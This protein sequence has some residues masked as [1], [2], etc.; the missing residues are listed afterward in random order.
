MV[1]ILQEN[2]LLVK[3][4]ISFSDQAPVSNDTTHKNETLNWIGWQSSIKPY[5]EK[6]CTTKDRN[7]SQHFQKENML[8]KMKWQSVIISEALW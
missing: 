8:T 7:G 1:C 3:S 5:L 4:N 2:I 6:D